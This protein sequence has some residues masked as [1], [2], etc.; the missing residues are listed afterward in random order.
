M[1]PPPV[2]ATTPGPYEVAVAAQGTQ[3][4]GGDA[5]LTLRLTGPPVGAWLYLTGRDGSFSAGDTEVRVAI[6]NGAG[7]TRVITT[8]PIAYRTVTSVANFVSRIDIT[9]FVSRGT[10]R[11]AISGFD[12]STPEGAFAY[13]VFR[14]NA[15]TPEKLI[16]VLDGADIG[17]FTEPP[18]LGPD[19]EVASFRFDPSA[20]ER[21]ARVVLAISDAE[22]GR[23]DEVFGFTGAGRPADQLRDTDGDGRIDIVDRRVALT[24]TDYP[25][26]GIEPAN[27]SGAL[28][29]HRRAFSIA[30]DCLGVQRVD[31]GC[32][33]G[34]EF[35]VV[36]RRYTIP[37]GHEHADFQ[38]Q[39]EDPENGDSFLVVFALNELTL[40]GINPVP[41]IEVIK[42]VTPT[43]MPEPGGPATFEVVVNNLGGESLRLASLVDDVFGNL[44]GRGTCVVPRT[45]PMGGSYRCTF[46]AAVSGTAAAPHH[47]TVTGAGTGVIS[48]LPVNDSDDAVVTFTRPGEPDFTLTKTASVHEGY[49]R[50]LV[51]YTF[52]VENTGSVRLENLTVTDDKLGPIGTVTLDPGQSATLYKTNYEL[53]TCTGTDLT[54]V[55]LCDGATVRTGFCS[56]PNTATASWGQI[57]RTASD[58][59]DI[60]PF[61]SIGDF[62]WED[63][64]KDGQQDAGEPGL[65][66][67]TV[68]LFKDGAPFGI[69]AVTDAAGGYLFADLKAGLAGV[70]LA[71][72]VQVLPDKVADR[73]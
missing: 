43:S 4:S 46:V 36:T 60:L 5:T 18:P 8:V 71:V 42:N 52:V 67:V 56:L 72:L 48:G 62:V 57:T 2:F 68:A 44:A 38:V 54:V 73:A 29:A 14:G 41:E 50:D 3:A 66:G 35:N 63:L 65:E 47:D 55:T 12:L 30:E 26:P 23:G 28:E 25:P 20:A 69:P 16:Q 15:G 13:A 32:G 7:A 34:P 40:E 21:R 64:D 45:I 70:L 49:P 51:T 39:S 17:Y 37:A 58:C 6:T 22:G 33:V 31:G 9:R 1:Q 19:S 24:R 27:A 11:L 59:V 61:G 10:N 53:P